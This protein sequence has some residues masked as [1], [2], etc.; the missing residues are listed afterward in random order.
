MLVARVHREILERQKLPPRLVGPDIWQQRL[1]DIASFERYLA[2]NGTLILK[3]FLHVSKAE[4]KRRFL[5]R[6]DTPS[7]NWKFSLGDVAERGRWSDYMAAYEDM[8]RN[9]ATKEAPWVV[10]PADH[11]WYARLIVAT[12][13]VDALRA[14]NLEFPRT[15]PER[16]RELAEARARLSKER[17]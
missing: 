17:G 6:L 3:F 2:R 16:A 5:E 9:T 7:K 10:V 11:K 15:T 8:I 13:T 14:L 12:A 4:Q 1:E